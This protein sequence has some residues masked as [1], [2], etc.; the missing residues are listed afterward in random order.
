MYVGKIRFNKYE[1]WSERRRKGKSE[2]LI[3]SD[4]HHEPIISKELWGKAQTLQKQKAKQPIRNFQGN[5]T[6]T[7]LLKCPVC[8]A[9]MVSSRTVNKLKSREKITRRYYSCGNFRSKGSSVCHANSVRAGEAEEKVYSRIQQV[10]SNESILKDIV[11]NIN[12]QK[13]SNII[14]LQTELEH[15]TKQLEKL[16]EKKKRYFDLYEES[17]LDKKL[18]NQRMEELNMECEQIQKRKSELAWEL[19]EENAQPIQYEVVRPILQQINKV[20]Q[21][22][23]PERIKTLLQLIVKKITV[24]NHKIQD[25]V[26]YFDETTPPSFLNEAPSELKCTLCQG[27]FKKRLGSMI[28]MISVLNRGHLI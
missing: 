27:Q 17:L 7:G 20:I 22:T 18:L 8:G 6:L 5:Y 16:D 23:S 13:E 2:H 21:T 9:T 19:G 3:L 12:E 28:E 10:V 11:Q 24:H 14:P 4:G 25:I 1:N 15:I 26:L